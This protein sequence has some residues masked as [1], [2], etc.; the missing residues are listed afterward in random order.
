MRTNVVRNGKLR[1]INVNLGIPA[2]QTKEMVEMCTSER[3]FL[4]FLLSNLLAS[5]ILC[6]D[7][8]AG[9]FIGSPMLFSWGQSPIALAENFPSFKLRKLFVH[10]LDVP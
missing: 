8:I 7:G 5:F 1:W 3:V 2:Q 9:F 6:I 10:D 4:C